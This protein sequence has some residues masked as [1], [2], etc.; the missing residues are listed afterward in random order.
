MKSLTLSKYLRTPQGQLQ[1][2]W[3]RA[4]FQKELLHDQS[5][6]ALQ[7]DFA[8][9]PTLESSHAQK[10]LLARS[11]ESITPYPCAIEW[12]LGESEYL[13]FPEHTFSLVTLPYTLDFAKDPWLTLQE[14]TRVLAPEGTLCL[15]G[16]NPSGLWWLRQRLGKACHFPAYL[17]R[18][19]TPQHWQKVQKWLRRLQLEIRHGHFGLYQPACKSNLH[20]QQWN[21]LNLAG[22]R[23][24]PQYSNVYFLSAKK[25]LYTPL[26]TGKVEKS[27]ST[28]H[29]YTKNPSSLT[30]QQ[31]H[32]NDTKIKNLD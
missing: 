1:T 13:P 10:I 4:I 8:A 14:A 23:W 15:T 11:Q 19:L 24:G 26:W 9:I 6:L 22:D 3:T 28:I 2:E 27:R 17:P 16:F 29:V 18:N 25:R 7:V 21:W 5:S 32:D 30:L 31:S 12:V 20:F